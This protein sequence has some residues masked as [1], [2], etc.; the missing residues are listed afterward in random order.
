MFFSDK[1]SQ[2]IKKFGE[3]ARLPFYHVLMFL[4]AVAYLNVP[5]P[6]R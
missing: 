5:L 4:V 2:S 3:F 1:V 6:A